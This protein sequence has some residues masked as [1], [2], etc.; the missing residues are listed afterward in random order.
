[1]DC[2]AGAYR[3]FSPQ[4]FVSLKVPSGVRHFGLPARV[5]IPGPWPFGLAGPLLPNRDACELRAFGQRENNDEKE[6]VGLSRSHV[7]QGP[8]QRSVVLHHSNDSNL[9]V[10]GSGMT[11]IPGRVN[12]ALL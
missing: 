5:D 9:R 10:S 7:P 2:Q 8:V 12:L 6:S 11:A 3:D 4:K 1:M